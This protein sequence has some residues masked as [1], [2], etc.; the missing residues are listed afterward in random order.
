M[1]GRHLP[2]PKAGTPESETWAGPVSP[3]VSA[4]S[5]QTAVLPPSSHMV[6]P[7][8][9]RSPGVCVY[10]CPNFS[11][12]KDTTSDWTEAHRQPRFNSGTSI[13]A[14]SPTR[15]HSG[16]LGVRTP[17]Y[18]PC[19]D[20]FSPRHLKVVGRVNK[21]DLDRSST[22]GFCFCNI[23]SDKIGELERRIGFAGAVDVAAVAVAIERQNES[24][25]CGD[26]SVF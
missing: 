12:Y 6:P 20:V 21:T 3:E 15:P 4:L 5:L 17:T 1:T 26:N 13:Q 9:T 19:G 23:L 7:L 8:C 16:V 24:G 11:S 14:L 22:V 18:K 2:A 10:V 25:P